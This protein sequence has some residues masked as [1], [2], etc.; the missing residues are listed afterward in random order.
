VDGTDT[1]SC[2][3]AG[4]VISAVESSGSVTTVLGLQYRMQK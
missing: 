1:G 2:T 3:V 4:S